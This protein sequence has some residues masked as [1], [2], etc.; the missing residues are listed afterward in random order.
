M[1]TKIQGLVLA[2]TVG[3]CSGLASA[4]EVHSSSGIGIFVTTGSEK[5]AL[6]YYKRIGPLL[7]L[8]DAKIDI[9]DLT[10]FLN[11]FGYSSLTAEKLEATASTDLMKAF[12]N[13]QVLSA[14]FFAPKIVDF[15]AAPTNPQY[16]YQAGWRKLVRLDSMS[17]SKAD[18]AGLGAAYVLF[19]YVQKDPTLD[20]FADASFKVE[21]F[22]TQ[23]IVVRPA[24]KK[25][26]E[27]AAL[28][29]DYNPRSQGY[30][31]SDAL[32]AA[33]DT[34][35]PPNTHE[36]Y[37]V[38]IACAQCHG[39]D[40]EAGSPDSTS[41][42]FPYITINY[43][44]TDQW[45]DMAKF[46]DFPSSPNAKLDVLY[47]GGSDHASNQYKAAFDVFRKLNTLI[48]QQNIDAAR[49]DG[50]SLFRIKAV[51]KWLSVHQSN[52]NPVTP[53]DRAL[54]LGNGSAVWKNTPDE[55][56]LLNL[57]DHYCFR[58]HSSVLYDVFDK[59]A[60]LDER[61]TMIIRV[62]RPSSNTTHM[63]QGR[64]LD[65]KTIADLVTYLTNLK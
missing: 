37:F 23:V 19:N 60:V 47:D 31:A 63:P 21:S 26:S 6:D 3:L 39:H 28:F 57:L 27:D 51:E 35:P 34:N 9:P 8:K 16:P 18:R 40:V 42:T 32:S 22:N 55:V 43:L 13:D 33:F 7:G 20:P 65:T 17:G 10:A 56:N 52:D 49:A 48:R 5:D 59:Q 62:Q 45:Y 54:D 2:M 36:N 46:G 11:Y 1:R 24:F 50:S 58:C 29:L 12:P 30:T 41:G 53:I 38:P 44:D 14:R 61:R 15:N 64:I 4:D 25:Q